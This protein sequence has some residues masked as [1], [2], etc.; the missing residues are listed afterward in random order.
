MS[1]AGSLNVDFLNT[2]RD[3]CTLTIARGWTAD[4][5]PTWSTGLNDKQTGR[6]VAVVHGKEDAL[7]AI[8]ELPI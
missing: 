5:K 3:D 4:G 7:S 2:V 6:S 1:A 8:M